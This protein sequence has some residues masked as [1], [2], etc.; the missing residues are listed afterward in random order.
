MNMSGKL[1]DEYRRSWTPAA[2]MTS[3]QRDVVEPVLLLIVQTT[4]LV[5]IYSARN[6]PM[7]SVSP[8]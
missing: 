8:L 3:A 1:L 4:L 6:G 2:S 5:M 7:L